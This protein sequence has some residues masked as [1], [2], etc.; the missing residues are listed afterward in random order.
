MVPLLR[1]TVLTSQHQG[2]PDQIR[3]CGGQLAQP[4][5]RTGDEQH[6]KPA[7]CWQ[8]HNIQ[9]H[10]PTTGPP[11]Y[12]KARRLAPDK[13]LVAK[14]EFE[15]MEKLGIIRRSSSPWASPLHIVSKSDGGCRPCGDFRR[16]NNATMPD[17]YPIPFLCDA[18][19]F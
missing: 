16:L 2:R 6:L 1:T 15:L 5:S 8:V 7:C 9:L 18:T 12:A 17:K 13:L 19:N 3:A 11:V 14:K 4:S 10:I